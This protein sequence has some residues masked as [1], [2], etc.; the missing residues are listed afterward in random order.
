MILGGKLGGGI[1][2][3][4]FCCVMQEIW[5]IRGKR[6]EKRRGVKGNE[7]D[8]IGVALSGPRLRCCQG[9]KIAKKQPQQKATR[10][11]PNKQPA[12]FL[13]FSDNQAPPPNVN[14]CSFSSSCP[15]T[16]LALSLGL[17]PRGALRGFPSFTDPSPNG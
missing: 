10:W 15:P 7:S 6:E 9:Q 16:A 8:L 1:Y 2:M 11:F 17:T 3:F 14:P 13:P 5:K 4:F 12:A